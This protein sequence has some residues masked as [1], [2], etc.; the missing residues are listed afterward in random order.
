LAYYGEGDKTNCL[1]TS[2]I[3]FM[4]RGV[5]HNWKQALAYFLVNKACSI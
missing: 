5:V 2:S 1:A 3:V 4:A